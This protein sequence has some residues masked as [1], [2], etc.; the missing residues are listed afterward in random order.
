MAKV[1]LNADMGESFGPW[2]MGNDAALLDIVTSA[3]VACGWHAGDADTMATTMALARDNGVNIGAHP[4]FADLQGF[5]R[6]RIKLTPTELENLVI[7]QLGAAQATAA[8]LGT[9][10]RHLKLHGA[11]ANMCAEDED[12]ARTA[13][14]AAL[15][16]APDIVIMAIAA[17]AQERAVRAL[18]CNWVGEI[19]ADRAYEDNGLLVDR[20]KPG[21]VIHDAQEA[22]DRILR[23]VDQQALISQ[24]GVK[25]PTQ[26]DT[27]C[28]HG[29]GETA[30]Q[31][32]QTLRGNLSKAGVDI[33]PF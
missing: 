28:L 13:Y 15:R 8:A 5:G 4:G 7:Y 32:A 10:L 17:T 16:V 27:I 29:D 23:M 22:S 6:R 11:L 30:V 19:F 26:V 31:I 25:I 3:N 14:N 2:P 33:R 9:S 18:D 24:N 1:D 12:M 20:S 21:A